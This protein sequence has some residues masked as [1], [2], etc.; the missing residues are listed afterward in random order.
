MEESPLPPAHTAAYK[1][2]KII[3]S[4]SAERLRGVIRSDGLHETPCDLGPGERPARQS[5]ETQR[6]RQVPGP[7]H[8]GPV[9]G[10]ARALVSCVPSPYDRDVL[11]FQVE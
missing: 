10:Q 4:R 5:R 7:E 6:A 9:V 8:A 3:R 2:M 11:G 1:K